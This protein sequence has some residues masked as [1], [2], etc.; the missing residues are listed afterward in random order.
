MPQSRRHG[1]SPALTRAAPGFLSEA[2]AGPEAQRD[3][4]NRELSV[5]LQVVPSGGTVTGI[6]CSGALFWLLT[7]REGSILSHWAPGHHLLPCH[8]L[9][10]QLHCPLFLAPGI[11]FPW[12]ATSSCCLLSN[13]ARPC[14]I[15]T[16]PNPHA[17]REAGA[18]THP[19]YRQT[20][21]FHH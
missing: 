4:A 6:S 9:L 21:G 20:S 16:S 2:T 18:I 19:F 3:W 1:A 12:K 8:G 15:I 5:A 13:G 7:P 11:L 10:E 14:D 17:A